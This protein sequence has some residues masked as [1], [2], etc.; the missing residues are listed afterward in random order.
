MSI[1]FTQVWAQ[2]KADWAGRSDSE[3][4]LVS[5]GFEDAL[6]IDEV[7][8]FG[9][10]IHGMLD[11]AS[12]EWVRAEELERI[13]DDYVFGAEAWNELCIAR[14]DPSD[15]IHAINAGTV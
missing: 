5:T 12:G 13:R 10:P 1:N 9:I 14:L 3:R 2:L 6:D 15:P 4:R 7:D 8:D 11:E